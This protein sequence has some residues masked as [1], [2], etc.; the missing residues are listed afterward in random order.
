VIAAIGTALGV[1]PVGGTAPSGGLFSL[2]QR[3]LGEPEYATRVEGAVQNVAGVD[4]VEVTAFDQ[5]GSADDPS[6]LVPPATPKRVE[7]VP[8][9]PTQ[10]LALFS[11]QFNPS[12]STGATG[13]GA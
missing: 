8:C 1:I 3:R 6:T 10:V 12:P 11:A 2:D 13:A 5:L 9:A 4:W 7:Q